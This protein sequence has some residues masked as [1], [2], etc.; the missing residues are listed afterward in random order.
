MLSL[1]KRDA[2]RNGSVYERPAQ[3]EQM[4]LGTAPRQAKVE[5]FSPKQQLLQTALK[6]SAAG[7]SHQ[8]GQ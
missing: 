6:T 7:A 8:M 3:A 2:A 4:E 5:T 1:G